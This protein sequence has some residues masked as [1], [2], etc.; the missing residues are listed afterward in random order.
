MKKTV[1]YFEQLMQLLHP[2]MPFIT[3]EIYH[4]LKER[5]DDLTI[6][7]LPAIS[8]SNDQVLINGIL[9]KDVI[10]A[11]RDARVKAQ[12]KPKDSVRLTILTDNKNTYQRIESILAKQVNAES[13][14]YADVPAGTN[15]ITVVVNKD[16]FYLETTTEMDL[17]SQREQLQ[18]DL[19]YLRGFLVS[20][21]KKLNNEKFVNN[22]K[23]DVV[24]I[25]RKKKADAE[26][27]IKVIEESLRVQ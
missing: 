8:K 1:E 25:E 27:K 17:S 14:S 19:D 23:P 20:V 16:K 18:K 12:L 22:A 26:A 11:I 6:K 2:F 13:I 3:E 10:T 9:L 7:L 15:S 21:D 4:Q 5:S 24:E